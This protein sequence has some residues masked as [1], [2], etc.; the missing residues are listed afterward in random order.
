MSETDKKSS[1]LLFVLAL[2]VAALA[3]AVATYIALDLTRPPA[4]PL[5]SQAAQ[6]VA[7][8]DPAAVAAAEGQLVK[9]YENINRQFVDQ[10]RKYGA[11]LGDIAA[12]AEAEGAATAAEQMRELG[13]ETDDLVARY[14]KIAKQ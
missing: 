7:P 12:V 13:R 4:A 6:S 10:L 3:G 5:T 14:D 2:A 1:P 11:R 8:P 9:L